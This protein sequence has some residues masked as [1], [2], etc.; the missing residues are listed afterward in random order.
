MHFSAHDCSWEV[1]ECNRSS[2]WHHQIR[3]PAE[4]G[5]VWGDFYDL[6][7]HHGGPAWCCQWE[8]QKSHGSI[9]GWMHSHHQHSGR[10]SSTK[11]SNL[12]TDE[13]RNIHMASCVSVFW[14]SQFLSRLH[15]VAQFGESELL[16]CYC[17]TWAAVVTVAVVMSL[18]RAWTLP[19]P[20]VR[21]WWLATGTTTGYTGLDQ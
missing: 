17:L 4:G 12:L 1:L 8:E 20:L 11:K 16:R 10:V 9:S 7:G 2:F 13:F 15:C 14:M 21:R 3:W 18:E 6:P 19:E 5:S